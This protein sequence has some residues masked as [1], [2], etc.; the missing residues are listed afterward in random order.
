M[1]GIAS[2]LSKIDQSKLYE[3]I[4]LKRIGSSLD[5]AKG[6]AFLASS[7]AEFITGANLVIDGGAMYTQGGQMD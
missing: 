7:D 5:V 3:K 2:D 4:P 1:E 6:V